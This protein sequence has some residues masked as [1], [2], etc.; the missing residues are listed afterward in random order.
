[1]NIRAS[2]LLLRSGA[3][4]HSPAACITSPPPLC[5]RRV[6]VC[7]S[8]T[9]LG[10]V[11]AFGPAKVPGLRTEAHCPAAL[12]VGEAGL[13]APEQRP[14]G[15]PGGAGSG[16]SGAAS[17]ASR[18]RLPQH[19]AGLARL[20]PCN[21]VGCPQNEGAPLGTAELTAA[22]AAILRAPN[23]KKPLIWSGFSIPEGSQLND[24]L[25]DER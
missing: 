23:V 17:P 2:P 15:R 21:A 4:G 5:L 6:G 10:R 8:C 24:T 7:L 11:D 20:G 16:R 18:C 19:R 25:R 13:S 1:M 22:P 3:M 12:A 9:T 14:P